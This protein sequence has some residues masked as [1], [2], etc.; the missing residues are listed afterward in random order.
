MTKVMQDV[1]VLEVAAWTFVPAAGAVLADWGA[2]VIKIEPPGGDPQRGLVTSTLMTGDAEGVNYL[3]EQPNRNKRSVALD[4]KAPGGR[5]LLLKIAESCDVF[6]TNWLEPARVKLGLD[7]ADLRAVNPSIIYVKGSSHGP[8]GPESGKG[9][10]DSAA[11]WSRSGVAAAITPATSEY[12]VTQPA[13]YNDLAGGQTIAGGIAAALLHRERTG[14]ATV[15]DVSLLG[16]GM[17]MMSAE[18]VA[19][20]AYG[21]TTPRKQGAHTDFPNPAVGNYRTRDGR[22][23][24]LMMLQSDRYWDEFCRAVGRADLADDPRFADSTL[25]YEHRAECITALDE[26]FVE[27]DLAHWRQVLA[28]IGGAWAAVQTA[29]EVAEDPQA[30]ANGYAVPVRKGNLEFPLVSNPVQFDR[31]VPELTP[32]PE[33]GQHTEEF[34]LE[35]GLSWDDIAR[36][37]GTGTI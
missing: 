33:V 11:V 28:P 36:L 29:Y 3:I 23:V 8:E 10:F 34:L 4:L 25:R 15:V 1:R 7:V 18:I 37:Q 6:L 2:D 12:P 35:I 20:R 26:T 5:D 16:L 14:E 17:W 32:A 21:L 31:A 9:S 13:A 30:L 27:H 19:S 24:Q 22:F